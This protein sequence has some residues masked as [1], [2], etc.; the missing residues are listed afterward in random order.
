MPSLIDPNIAPDGHHIIHAFALATVPYKD[1]EGMDWESKEYGKKRMEAEDFLWND[2]K[3]YVTK[4][5]E[6]VAKGILKVGTPLTHEQLFRGT[7]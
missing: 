4:S 6:R 2:F 1:W 7:I 5:R 3:E